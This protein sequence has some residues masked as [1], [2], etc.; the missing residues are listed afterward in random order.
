MGIALRQDATLFVPPALLT[1]M[2]CRAR[3][4]IEGDVSPLL[5]LPAI[6]A[7]FCVLRPA[8]ALARRPGPREPRDPA[9]RPRP[10]WVRDAHGED[11]PSEHGEQSPRVRT[12]IH[13]EP[14][15][16]IPQLCFEVPSHE[17]D[18]TS[19]W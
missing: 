6:Q 8:S 5:N 9:G 18:V 17:P 19:G 13:G 2:R 4:V 3:L 11:D 1:A 12:R 15:G 10:G 14:A 16:F 7:V